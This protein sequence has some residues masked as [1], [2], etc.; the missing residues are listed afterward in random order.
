M[1]IQNSGLPHGSGERGQPEA[2]V[3]RPV[4]SNHGPEFYP[5]LVGATAGYGDGR[6]EALQSLVGNPANGWQRSRRNRLEAG[7][8]A[9]LHR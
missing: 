2:T 4:L 9:R 8:V 1:N 6:G 7:T 3:A 5:T